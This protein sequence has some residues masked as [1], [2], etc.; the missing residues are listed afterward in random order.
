V[1]QIIYWPHFITR[2]LFIYLNISVS[3]RFVP[4]KRTCLT[5]KFGRCVD[6]EILYYFPNT[7]FMIQ[8][9]EVLCK[10]KNK[11]Y[12]LFHNKSTILYQKIFFYN[13]LL[14]KTLLFLSLLTWREGKGWTH[15]PLLNMSPVFHSCFCSAKNVHVL[16]RHL[17]SQYSSVSKW[18][19]KGLMTG[20]IFL[21]GAGIF[22]FATM[23]RLAS[24]PTPPWIQWFPRDLFSGIKWLDVKLTIH[25]FLVL[26]SRK[27]APH[28]FLWHGA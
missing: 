13:K 7:V 10:L 11:N 25:I 22:L 2:R 9:Q 21:A 16:L 1:K 8:F 18:M 17:I 24:G 20:I 14:V 12:I 3:N 5:S 23:W 15:K 4:N 19:G 26:R 27:C 28:T 6:S